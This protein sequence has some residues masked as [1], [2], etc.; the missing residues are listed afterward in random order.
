MFKCLCVVQGGCD[1][2][3]RFNRKLMFCTNRGIHLS[4]WL[5]WEYAASAL[6]N[7]HFTTRCYGVFHFTARRYGIPIL[8][9]VGRIYV[10]FQRFDRGRKPN[11]RYSCDKNVIPRESC[12][13]FDYR[14]SFR[15]LY[16]IALTSVTKTLN[17]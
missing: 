11:F 1:S 9:P 2:C 7:F 3:I 6:G 14:L 12:F 15:F 8:L 16:C 13:N 17:G 10:T 5:C 4:S